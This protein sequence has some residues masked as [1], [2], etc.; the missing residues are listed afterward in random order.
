[1]QMK[2]LT[3][4]IAVILLAAAVAACGGGGG[5]PGSTG[6][7]AG[8]GGSVPLGT[9]VPTGLS[10][11]MG[12]TQT[13]TI[14]GGSAP[15]SAV[16]NNTAIA[17]ASVTGTSLAITGSGPG[18]A[19][20]NVLDSANAVVPATVTVTVAD[21]R[22]TAPSSITLARGVGS[23]QTYGISGGVAPYSV[24]SSNTAVA[25][26]TLS[27]PSTVTISGLTSGTAS[28]V[29]RDALNTAVTLGVTVAT[30]Q[31]TV[32]P[33]TVSAFIGDT[34][35]ST[36]SGGSAPFSIVEGFPDSADVD[37]GTLSAAGTFTANPSGDILRV[38]VKQAVGSD[39]IVVRDSGN[40]TAVFTLTG[41][42][43]TN[44]IN[45]APSAVTITG[46][47]GAVVVNEVLYGGVGTVQLFSSDPS[48]ISVPAS[49]TG[50]ASGTTVKLTK[51]TSVVCANPDVV[52]TAVDSLGQTATSTITI[53]APAEPAPPATPLC[54]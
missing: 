48:L 54:P 52:I 1:M 37:V 2:K 9:T 39:T 22:T 15:Y 27:T 21:L 43:G 7:T 35:Y 17:T 38:V 3:R 8:G 16:S 25:T 28:V 41:R 12:D 36:I 45:L 29:V 23:A 50:S 30:S 40:N 26:A 4:R 51:T 44:A 42:A 32:N 49:V 20:V 5:S 18:T 14:S 19:T 53:Q 33:T 47:A 46:G 11:K 34:V 10:I 13:F 24:T 6:G 31:M